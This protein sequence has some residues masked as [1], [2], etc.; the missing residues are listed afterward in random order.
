MAADKVLRIDSRDNVLVALTSL[1]AGEPIVFAG[2][3][4]VLVRNFQTG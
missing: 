2:E 4:L 3:F 1:P